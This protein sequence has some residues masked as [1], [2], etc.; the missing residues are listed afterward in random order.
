MPCWWLQ[1]DRSAAFI[2]RNNYS[3][4]YHFVP[5]FTHCIGKNE[6]LFVI[7][8]LHE[9]EV[10]HLIGKLRTVLH[11]TTNPMLIPMLLTR[12]TLQDVSIY[13]GR[14]HE[15]LYNI[16]RA[17]GMHRNPTL[18]KPVER[19]WANLD[20]LH[21]TMRDLTSVNVSLAHSNYSCQTVLNIVDFLDETSS[22]LRTPGVSRSALLLEDDV[23]KASEN[24]V[25]LRSWTQGLQARLT[26][27]TQRAQAQVQTV[28]ALPET[29][30]KVS[31]TSTIDWPSQVYTLI[32]H[33]DNATS[34]QLSQA[35]KAVAE[36]S[37]ADSAAMRRVAED[38]KK[39]AVATQK[40]SAA[41]RVVAFVTVLFLPGTFTA[42]S[43]H[44]L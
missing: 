30:C 21:E 16:E 19:K 11:L 44:S 43:L 26:Y 20:I 39:I 8:G 15:D 12:S 4:S 14:L 7:Q 31:E 17:T 38:S 6:T 9:N 2:I 42:V 37:L 22:W 32:A 24:T 27:L 23:K 3:T 34:I 1:A 33:Q 41:M 5:S 28:S 10:D 25:H 29:F 13:L 35:S 18:A 40:D 36:A